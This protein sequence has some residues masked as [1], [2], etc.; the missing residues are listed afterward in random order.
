[1]S[2]IGTKQTLG[3]LGNPIIATVELGGALLMSFL[4]LMVPAAAVALIVLFLWLAIRL[5]FLGVHSKN[6]TQ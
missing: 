3:G 6:R 1:M 5:V 4:A 2:A